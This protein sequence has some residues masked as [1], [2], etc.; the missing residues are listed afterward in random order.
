[1]A[2]KK[3]SGADPQFALQ[4][5]VIK[6]E[7]GFHRQRIRPSAPVLADLRQS[8]GLT[9][10][11]MAL[12]LGIDVSYCGGLENGKRPF[13][14]AG[15]FRDRMA[16]IARHVDKH[17]ELSEEH[18]ELLTAPSS[19]KPANKPANQPANKPAGTKLNI[20]LT[21][22]VQEKFRQALIDSPHRFQWQLME[23]M[24]NAYVAPAPTPAPA[25]PRDRGIIAAIALTAAAAGIAIGIALAKLD[26]SPLM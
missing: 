15:K 11:E 22:E 2:K 14:K 21:D 8:L 18:L 9:Q 25:Q 5:N 24:V 4:E 13:P 26:P 10:R 17:G 16:E 20:R 1:M 6:V 23:E 12:L 7:D 3:M 19:D